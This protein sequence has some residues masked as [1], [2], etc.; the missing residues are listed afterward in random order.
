MT[1]I[2][3]L[4]ECTLSQGQPPGEKKNERRCSF[5]RGEPIYESSRPGRQP[6]GDSPARLFYGGYFLVRYLLVVLMIQ[7]ILRYSWLL[8]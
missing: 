6:A 1:T 2:P 3:Y 4:L 5:R 8:G 7:V